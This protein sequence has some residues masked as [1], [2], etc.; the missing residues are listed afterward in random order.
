MQ[1]LKPIHP[2]LT[3]QVYNADNMLYNVCVYM[4]CMCRNPQLL[5]LRYL[6]LLLQ[7]APETTSAVGE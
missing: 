7:V 3:E 5:S 4:S 6:P 1:T 2:R